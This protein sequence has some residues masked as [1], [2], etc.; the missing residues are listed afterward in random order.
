VNSEQ[1][2]QTAAPMVAF[3]AGLL[4]G[5]GVFGLDAATW[6]TLI[7]AVLGLGVTVW[8]AIK[9]MKKNVIA[10]AANLPDV[11]SITLSP[12]ASAAT[13]AGTPGNVTK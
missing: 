4:A 5:K 3:L 7:G 9:G 10:A 2:K 1:I 13:L 11:Q 8:G 12:E 6:A